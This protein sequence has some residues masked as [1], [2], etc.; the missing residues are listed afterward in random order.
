MRTQTLVVCTVELVLALL[1]PAAPAAICTANVSATPVV[2]DLSP[3]RDHPVVRRD[4]YGV[5]HVTAQS[6]YGLNFQTGFEDARDRLVQLEFFRRASKGT[7]AEVFGRT[8]IDADKDTRTVLYTDEERQYFFSTLPCPTQLALQAYVDGVNRYIHLIYRGSMR[9]VPHELYDIGYLVSLTTPSGL[10]LG[11]TYRILTVHGEAV[12]KPG[13]WD[14]TDVVAVAEMLVAQFG[15]GGGRQLRD[16]AMRNYLATFL[17][18]HGQPNPDET[19]M[20]IFNDVRWTNDPNAPTTVPKTG[21]V[22]PVATQNGLLTVPEPDRCE[23]GV[24]AQGGGARVVRSAVLDQL[25]PASV[26]RALADLHRMQ[27]EI[28]QR[29][30]E[31]GVPRLHGSN[32]WVVAPDRSA[33]GQ[34]LLWGGPQEGFDVPN[35]DNELY[36]R[37]PDLTVGGMKIPGAPGILIGMTDRFAYTTTS[38]EMDNSTVYVESLDPARSPTD[39]Q[40]ADSQYFFLFNGEYH[41]MARRVEVIHWAGEDPAQAPAYGL[42]RHAPLAFNVFRVNDCDPQHFH[43]PVAS[44]DLSDATHPRAYTIKTAYWKNETSTLDGFYGFNTAKTF[45]EFWTAVDKVVSLHNFFFA[46]A[47]GNIA[48]WSAG[49]KV[50]FPPAFD[51]RFPSDGT[52]P[53]EWLPNADGTMSTPFSRL[54]YSVNPEQGYL[55]NWNTKPTDAPCVLEGNSHDEHWGEIYRSQRIAFLLDHNRN[56]NLEDMR[57]IAKDIGTIDN[58]EDTVA[59]MLDRFLPYLN[60]AYQ[61]LTTAQ[62]PLVDA[63]AH[64]LLGSTIATLNSWHDALQDKMR[65][66][67][68]DGSGH[69]DPAYS[70]FLGQPGLSILF[71]WWYAFKQNLFGGGTSASTP[72]VGTITFADHS[73]DGN[74]Y[75]GETTYNMALHILDGVASGVPQQYPGD[76]FGGYRDELIIESL[77]DAIALLQGTTPLPRMSYS[78]CSGN[79]IDTPGFGTSNVTLWGWQAPSN[80]DFDCLDSLADHMFASGTLPTHFGTAPTHNRS[81]YMQYLSVSQ[82]PVGFNIIAPGQSAFVRHTQESTGKASGHVGDQAALFRTFQYKPMALP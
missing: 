79:R 40:T 17:R 63:L 81:T 45:Q 49:S 37:T 10:P 62:S 74:D 60:T 59:P 57:L 41:P 65:I 22:R 73:I 47:L 55:V 66:F 33:T 82:P 2:C 69:Y 32:A 39:P 7:L 34:A 20:Q 21:A 77:N 9:R 6:F 16:L 19:A 43:G 18:T 51:D 75:L 5:P 61:H 52:G 36:G 24:Q 46:D 14:V 31:F 58:S 15:G 70:P 29:A 78:S 12:F 53:A 13:P 35:I 42:V 26:L 64:P 48:Y 56:V 30:K 44:F 67:P 54:I 11:A 72:Y 50:N 68:P 25:P 8:Q 23:F 38:G 3:T 28:V 1:A 80:L 76:Y 71:Q 4:H 27:D